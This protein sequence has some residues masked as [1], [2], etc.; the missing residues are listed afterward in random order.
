M[1]YYRAALCG[2]FPVPSF[3]LTALFVRRAHELH[4]RLVFIKMRLFNIN[5]I[6]TPAGYLLCILS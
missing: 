6:I 5:E 3:R 4:C 1:K 2:R